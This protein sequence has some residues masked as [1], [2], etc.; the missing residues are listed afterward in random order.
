MRTRPRGDL[1]C[2]RGAGASEGPSTS[3]GT[4]T[5][6]EP[7]SA[8]SGESEGSSSGGP[9]QGPDEA[10]GLAVDPWGYSYV[11]G[12]EIE[13]LQPQAFALRLYP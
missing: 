2:R 13:A 6:E 3:D 12:Y 4:S 10:A 9:G 1:E 8:S 7:S 11:V 5:G